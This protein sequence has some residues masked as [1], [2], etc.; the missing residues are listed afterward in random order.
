[1]RSE[2]SNIFMP[3]ELV[4]HLIQ[5]RRFRRRV[6]L[7]GPSFSGLAFSGRVF[8]GRVFSGRVFSGRVFSVPRQRHSFPR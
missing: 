1:V 8:S 3:C 2:T 4:R 7:S 6:M 5:M